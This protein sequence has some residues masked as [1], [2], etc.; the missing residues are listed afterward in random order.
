MAR[1]LN[2]GKGKVSRGE[3]RSSVSMKRGQVVR[4]EAGD[5]WITNM[6]E[7]FVASTIKRGTGA[8]IINT[9][10]KAMF[11]TAG[12]LKVPRWNAHLSYKTAQELKEQ[13]ILL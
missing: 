13:G 5:S 3:R 4:R 10:A 9:C 8:A 7:A 1:H 12:V 2:D 11:S 6:R